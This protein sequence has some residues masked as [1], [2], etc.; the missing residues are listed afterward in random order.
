LDVELKES[1]VLNCSA[2]GL[3]SPI[4]WWTKNGEVQYEISSP[5]YKIGAVEE[6][7]GGL[8]ECLAQ[9]S[10]GN[11]TRRTVL[12]VRPSL[13]DRAAAVNV[14][15]Q[16][17]SLVLPCSAVGYPKP[18]ITWQK[19]G[20]L[21]TDDSTRSIFVSQSGSLV[22]ARTALSD[23]GMYRCKATSPAGEITFPT[24]LHVSEEASSR[25]SS[26]GVVE[27]EKLNLTCSLCESNCTVRWTK[28][29]QSIEKSDRPRLAI[30]NVTAL[31]GGLYRCADDANGGQVET[32]LVTFQ[33][34]PSVSV[35][36]S[37]NLT[38]YVSASV[39]LNLNVIGGSPWSVIWYKEESLVKTGSR[40]LVTSSSLVIQE[41]ELSDA[42]LYFAHVVS[43]FCSQ[44]VVFAVSVLDLLGCPQISQTVTENDPVKF[45]C[46][47][48]SAS[49]KPDQFDSVV[50]SRPHL[51]QT[52]LA[53]SR[54]KLTSVA[55]L[56]IS[57]VSSLDVGEY[58][59]GFQDVPGVHCRW[60]L[61]VTSSEANL[62]SVGAAR[63]TTN[64]EISLPTAVVAGAL[65]L[66]GLIV[67]GVTV[68]LCMRRRYRS[69]EKTG[70]VELRKAAHRATLASVSSSSSTFPIAVWRISSS[71]PSES[72]T[73]APRTPE[74]C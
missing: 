64:E 37:T 19:G 69:A 70:T 7:D 29:G 54:Y 47:Y 17:E 66:L 43:P 59:C 48:R 63:S 15:R 8:Y 42:G 50:W 27:G 13:I 60:W 61:A 14:V 21:L 4:Y 26:Y 20:V 38:V 3:P 72:P 30:E 51:P 2:T 35:P 16:S 57:G 45:I 46:E 18:V 1:V 56:T 68:G 24:Y 10:Q 53:A 5:E 33:T 12:R 73:S 6:G 58:S 32:F 34:C 65:L 49:P 23:T 44:K 28:D 39:V 52:V 22:F 67:G 36:S 71:S 31:D 9:N 25:V 74:P 40:I 55:T 62:T 41:A 11:A